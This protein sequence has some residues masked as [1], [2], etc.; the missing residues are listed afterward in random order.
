LIIGLATDKEARSRVVGY[1]AL[2]NSIGK[3][4]SGGA[5]LQLSKSHLDIFS[6]EKS[7]EGDETY[8]SIKER[9]NIDPLST[10][11]I[12]SLIKR[13]LEKYIK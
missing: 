11:E 6:V 7:K 3:T 8:I 13:A 4:L 9:K 5:W 12:L 1:E 2:E 10:D